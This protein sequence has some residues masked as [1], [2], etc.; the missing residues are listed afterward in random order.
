MFMQHPLA[1]QL[2]FECAASFADSAA[3][4]GCRRLNLQPRKGRLSGGGVVPDLDWMDTTDG[5]QGF[6]KLEYSPNVAL[7]VSK[8][9]KL[10]LGKVYGAPAGWHWGSWAEVA[11]AMG[12][13]GGSRRPVKPYYKDQGGWNGWKWAGVVRTSSSSATRCR[14]T[15]ASPPVR[16][17]G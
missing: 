17:K 6:K 3:E 11:A 8:T 15:D 14:P 13:G 16:G 12:G 9:D 2:A 4:A 5:F 1:A 7:A 10:E